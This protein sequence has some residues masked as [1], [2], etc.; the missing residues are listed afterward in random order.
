MATHDAQVASGHVGEP[1]PALGTDLAGVDGPALVVDLRHSP[2]PRVMMRQRSITVCGGGARKWFPIRIWPVQW[3]PESPLTRFIYA[4]DMKDSPWPG[5]GSGILGDCGSLDPG[6]IPGPGPSPLSSTG[7]QLR[8]GGTSCRFRTRAFR[9]SGT[10]RRAALARHPP[11]PSAWD[12]RR[13]R[14]R[15]D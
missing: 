1:R 10:H 2:S 15:P 8:N 9:N 14:N 4:K 11:C 5:W 6:S 3:R 12:V 7:T 13:S